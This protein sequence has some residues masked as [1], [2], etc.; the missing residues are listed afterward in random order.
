MNPPQGNHKK[1]QAER[2]FS[3][4]KRKSWHFLG[5]IIPFSYY[6]AGKEPLVMVLFFLALLS[7]LIDIIRLKNSR[8]NQVFIRLFGFMLKKEEKNFLNGTTFF[9]TGALAAIWFFSQKA[10][11]F[12]ILV[13]AV[14]D[15]LAS[16]VG[17]SLGRIRIGTKTLEGSLT[18]F[19]TA[20]L[21]SYLFFDGIT[22]SIVGGAMIAAFVEWVPIVVD[23]N[24]K[25]PVSVAA[26]YHFF[27]K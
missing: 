5:L 22:W 2:P 19:L 21:L 9:L 6:Y 18:F 15:P 10:A 11:I 4:L 14:C 26:Y 16:I 17:K 25:I 3:T 12:A 23:D 8:V 7:L 1:A 13:L 27:V 20:L 24:L